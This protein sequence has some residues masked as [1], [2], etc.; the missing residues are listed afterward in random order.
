MNGFNGHVKSSLRQF[1]RRRCAILL[2]FQGECR[3]QNSCKVRL[4]MI[5]IAKVV[6][7]YQIG[8]F[9]CFVVSG[10]L[11]GLFFQCRENQW[12]YSYLKCVPAVQCRGGFRWPG[13][14]ALRRGCRSWSFQVCCGRG[15]LGCNAYPRLFLIG[16]SRSCG[17]ACAG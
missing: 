3:I 15:V 8:N 11:A 7:S 6:I 10:S 4:A 14:C 13:R 2:R 12:R 5:L 16:G 1:Y 17:A 9:C